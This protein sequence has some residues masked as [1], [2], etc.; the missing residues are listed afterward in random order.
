MIFYDPLTKQMRPAEAKYRNNNGNWEEALVLKAHSDSEGGGFTIRLLF[1]GAE[2]QTVRDRLYFSIGN[3]LHAESVAKDNADEEVGQTAAENI[4]SVLSCCSDN[5]TAASLLSTRRRSVGAYSFTCGPCQN[6]CPPSSKI[7]EVFFRAAACLVALGVVAFV[8]YWYLSG[9]APLFAA[10]TPF[11]L[12]LP[13]GVDLFFSTE[14]AVFGAEE[15]AY[16]TYDFVAQEFLFCFYTVIL[17]VGFHVSHACTKALLLTII[18]FRSFLIAETLRENHIATMERRD[19]GSDLEDSNL[20]KIR[21]GIRK[22]KE[23][24]NKSRRMPLLHCFFAAALVIM[25]C[26]CTLIRFASTTS[27][28]L[29]DGAYLNSTCGSRYQ[30][31]VITSNV[32]TDFYAT[33]NSATQSSYV[34]FDIIYPG[35]RFNV[36]SEIDQVRVG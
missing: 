3:S 10:A 11:S 35:I 36:F 30:E 33:S 7:S 32:S 19:H 14:T 25:A 26:Y 17:F 2:R 22:R 31:T 1:S 28:S 20:K 18:D 29:S 4:T 15:N 34:P 24:S 23:C 6:D 13:P 12:L 8:F 27:T 5:L 21:K 16:A 9:L